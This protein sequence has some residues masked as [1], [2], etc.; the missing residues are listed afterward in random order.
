MVNVHA[1][2]M[3]RLP[4]AADVDVVFRD[5]HVA[6]VDKPAGIVSVRE[7]RE[8]GLSERRRERQPT[9]DE[10]VAA[11]LRRPHDRRPPA[12][13]PVH[14]LDRDTSGLMVFARTPEAE[15]ELVRA[16]KAHDLDRL[17]RAAVLGRLEGPATFDT[18]LARDRGDGR[19]GSLPS[20]AAVPP[21]A[22]RA[23]THARPLRGLPGGRSVVECRL[24][25]GRT[26]QIRIHLGEAGLPVC[27]DKLYG[28]RDEQRPPPRQAL[29]AAVLAFR[30]PATAEAVRFESPWPDDLDRW[31]A[32]LR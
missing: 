13:L 12:V 8:R 29:H 32:S 6:V 31:V 20:G 18:Q 7:R 28:R 21:D 2:S 22:R 19:R 11:K 27:G 1:E 25:T 17:Y 14:R 16:F 24:E 26:H 15:K 23:V 3:A 5:R 10:L 4:T 9:L 30:H